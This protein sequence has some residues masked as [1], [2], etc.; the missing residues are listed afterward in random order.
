MSEV[1]PSST[2]RGRVREGHPEAVVWWQSFLVLRWEP[3][4]AMFQ[5]W[6][7]PDLYGNAGS[8]ICYE[9]RFLVT[10]FDGAVACF[11]R[12]VKENAADIAAAALGLDP[13]K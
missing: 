11:E 9:E 13:Q 1:K 3:N 8:T 5:V 12:I 4:Y 2:R 7:K 10:D 6:F